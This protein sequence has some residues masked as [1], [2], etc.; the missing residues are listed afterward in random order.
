MRAAIDARNDIEYQT[1][2]NVHDLAREMVRLD[3]LAE[4][5]RERRQ[6]ESAAQI[7]ELREALQGRRSRL[8]VELWE[9]RQELKRRISA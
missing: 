1:N 9:W 2:L 4:H 3:V 8:M 7:D 6:F 5:A